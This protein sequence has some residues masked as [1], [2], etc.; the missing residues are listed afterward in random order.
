M[1]SLSI[2]YPDEDTG[3]LRMGFK[4]SKFRKTDDVQVLL[5]KVAK[6]LLTRKGSNSFLPSSGSELTS[7]HSSAFGPDDP[8]IKVIV[9]STIADVEKTL[10]D[11]QALEPSTPDTQK[12][13]GLEI[14]NLEVAADDPTKLMVEI[15]VHTEARQ[16]FFITV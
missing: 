12:L 3:A 13:L 4:N 15:I 5:D 6:L 11:E 7:L 1:K 10:L 8:E 16:S 2:F 9:H 14:S